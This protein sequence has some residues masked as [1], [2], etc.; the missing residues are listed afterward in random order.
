MDLLEMTKNNLKKEGIANLGNVRK[1]S[2]LIVMQSAEVKKLKA[3]LEAFLHQN[4]YRNYRVMRMA[5]KG[6]RIVKALFDEFCARPQQLPPR[7]RDRALAGDL[8]RTVC[9]YLA[10]MTDRY[11]QD[12]YLRL[13]QPSAFA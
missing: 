7:Y 12:E 4:V 6:Q 8:K 2:R 1:C 10:G 3:E 13:F 9:D 5:C 11:A